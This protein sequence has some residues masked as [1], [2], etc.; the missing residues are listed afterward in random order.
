M[1]RICNILVIV[2]PTAGEHPAVTK[3]ALLA[4]K[5]DARL[6]LFICDTQASRE[7][8]LAASALAQPAQPPVVDLKTKLE[9]LAGPLR[10][11]GLDVTTEATW[12]D[13][14]HEALLDRTRRTTAELV[15]K[16]THHHTLAQRTF[17][18]NTDWQ[19]IRGCP[20]PLLL[21]KPRAWPSA[22]RIVAA[23]DPGHVNDKPV[24]LD[25]CILEEA[26]AVSQRLGG[27]L[28]VV[29]VYLPMAIVATA[30]AVPPM[31][32]A[33][34]PEALEQE[35]KSRL[36][37]VSALV[38][39]YK[40]AAKNIHLEIGGPGEALPRAAR[41]IDADIVVMGAISRSGLKRIFIGSTAED[42]LEH[43]PCDALIVKTPNFAELLP[44]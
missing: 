22:P 41:D 8:R 33:V 40:V 29:H 38:S 39:D 15:I 36:K 27:E 42:V 3:G 6:E 13:P 24:L 5:F 25:R 43:L 19:L 26:A 34:S 31:A 44:I 32:A 21:T 9:V 35:R 20:V 1:D 28:H 11:R 17:L 4:E 12:S 7:A 18:T 30:T 2:D 16:D 10:E 23:V 37:E 14:L